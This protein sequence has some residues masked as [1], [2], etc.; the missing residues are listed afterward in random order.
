[1]SKKS[2]LSC[3]AR[4]PP[5]NHC[6]L[7]SGIF[8]SKI[9]PPRHVYVCLFVRPPDANSVAAPTVTDENLCKGT[10]C[11]FT[12]YAMYPYPYIR[13]AAT[14]LIWKVQHSKLLVNSRQIAWPVLSQTY[15][16]KT[17]SLSGILYLLDSLICRLSPRLS[18]LLWPY[19]VLLAIATHWRCGRCDA[20][21]FEGWGSCIS[22]PVPLVDNSF[23][24]QTIEWN[25][26]LLWA[27]DQN[28]NISEQIL[29]DWKLCL[30][31]W[32]IQWIVVKP[33]SSYCLYFLLTSTQSGI[34]VNLIWAKHKARRLRDHYT[35]G[36]HDASQECDT[37]DMENEIGEI[38][39][40]DH[41]S[42]IM[43]YLTCMWAA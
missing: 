7:V 18:L 31:H 20:D 10:F 9:T 8:L 11:P 5:A 21:L 16:I 41:L 19:L 22:L 13:P 37:E 15:K 14:D 27:W 36:S 43:L 4:F 32:N 28:S 35:Y 34:I 33:L 24:G 29:E 23:W 40:Y 2:A 30:L 39:D 12:W 25:S 3:W 1:M 26:S 42:G 6:C 38:L 17:V